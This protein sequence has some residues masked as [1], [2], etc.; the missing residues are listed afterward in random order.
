MYTMSWLLAAV[1]LATQDLGAASASRVT[2]AER[3]LDGRLQVTAA[4]LADVRLQGIW[5]LD[6]QAA[7]FADL[8]LLSELAPL[9]S[10]A[11]PAELSV[12]GDRSRLSELASLEDLAGDPPL[13]CADQDP[14]DALYKEARKL[15]NRGHYA[16]AARAFAD[17]TRRYPRSS[18]APDAHYWQAFA[19]Y[20]TGDAANYRAARTVLESQKRLYPSAATLGDAETLY[21][22][23]QGELARQGDPDAAEWV[24]VH[25]ESA[26]QPP[27][28]PRPPRPPTPPPPPTPARSQG[29]CPADENDDDDPRIAALNAL[30][31][32]D[33]DAAMPILKQVL[34]RRDRCSVTLRRKAVFIISQKRTAETEDILL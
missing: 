5:S 13:A 28:P 6:A 33:A 10:L 22:R 2:Q 27:Q 25:A 32:M 15:L 7:Q 30:L 4:A 3:G 11:T 12:F 23:I 17:L 34:A 26:A 18:Y 8:S 20:K 1:T 14:G 24:R 9:G 19:L 31:Q 16:D 29:G 21:A